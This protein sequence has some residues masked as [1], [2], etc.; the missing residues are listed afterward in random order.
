MKKSLFF[1][2][3]ASFLFTSFTLVAQTKGFFYN[4]TDAKF[5]AVFPAQY[6]VELLESVE[7]NTVKIAA[8][9]ENQSYFITY[10]VHS[11]ELTELT[12]LA[13]TSLNSFSEALGTKT[14][15]QSEWK[16]KKNSGLQATLYIEN[17]TIKIKYY[18]VLVGHIQYQLVV[19][20][21][22]E[23]FDEKAS[24][25]FIKSFKISK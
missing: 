12:E 22:N 4:N 8:S 2:M 15:E 25:A 13:Y 21:Q 11:S 19:L 10:T 24:N 6:D 17:G 9:T 7:A 16:V 23:S 14:T 1:L 20:A 3:L 5:S 18:V